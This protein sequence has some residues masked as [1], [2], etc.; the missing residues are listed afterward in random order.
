MI[1]AAH[2]H[3]CGE[4]EANRAI[5]GIHPTN[6]KLITLWQFVWLGSYCKVRKVLSLQDIGNV[7]GSLPLWK[8]S[9]ANG[10]FFFFFRC[11]VLSFSGQDFWKRQHKSHRY[12]RLMGLMA[13]QTLPFKYVL[14]RSSSLDDL[15]HSFIYS[16]NKGWLKSYCVSGA[17]ANI[18]RQTQLGPFFRGLWAHI[19]HFSLP[20]SSG[21][22]L[23]FWTPD[24]GALIWKKSMR[25]ILTRKKKLKV[26]LVYLL[27]YLKHIN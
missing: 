6:K 2:Q 4:S 5:G 21:P 22:L 27:M 19:V 16:F 23:L 11:S 14:Q 9:F 26:L 20:V 25:K 10:L 17:T 3:V 15:I 7:A 12:V 1:G 18:R 13:A 24:S 8:E